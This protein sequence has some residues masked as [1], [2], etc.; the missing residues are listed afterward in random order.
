MK[1]W[2]GAALTVLVLVAAAGA[3][4]LA[5][6]D[7]LQADFASGLLPPGSP[8]HLLGRSEEHTSELQSLGNIVCRLLLEIGR[9]SCRERV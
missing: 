1:A 4:W 8:G 2:I 5:A 3:P 7:P 9:A 6:H